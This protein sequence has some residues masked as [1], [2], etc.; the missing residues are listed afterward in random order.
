MGLFG[1]HRKSRSSENIEKDDKSKIKLGAGI[2]LDASVR[3]STAKAN[4]KYSR[5]DYN[6]QARKTYYDDGN[7]HKSAIDR[8]FSSGKTVRDP[9]SGAKLVK[10]QKQ[11]KMQFGEDWQN[12]AAEADHIDPLSQIANRTKKNPFLTT[13]DVREIGNSEDNFQ[14]LSRKLNQTNKDVGKGGSTQ[15]EWA[16]DSTRMEGLADNIESGESIETVKKRIKENGKAAEKRN[17]KRAY[18]KGFKNAIGTAR[19][20]GRAG[21]QNAGITALT[22]SGIMNVVSVIK[23]EKRGEEAVTDTIRDGGKAA[24]TGYAM[25]G[26]LTVVSQ[27]LSYSSSEFVQALAKSNVPGKVITAVLVTGD[28][29]KKWGNGE[30][31]TQEC[32]IQLGDKGL[33]MATMGY[34]MAV[35]Q[36]LIP[37]PVVGGA[38]GALVGA[39]LTTNLY[40]GLMNDLQT[41]QLEHQERMRIIAECN[42][43]AEQAR[44]FREQLEAYLDSYFQEYKSCF[45]EAMS[46]IHLAYQTNDADGIIAGANQITRKMGGKVQ[47]ETVEEFECFLDD[48]SIDVL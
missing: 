37:I 2:A 13:D 4:A 40:N 39:M 41:K 48:D 45:D 44:M 15:A 26:G 28:T 9:Y 20:A 38:V 35:G 32:L 18:K 46:S 24:V 42:E 12:H 27:T 19:E 43:A 30:M 3:S 21:A 7:A 11:A 36:A 33:N 22:M 1:F 8:A 6:P 5:P 34:S 17:D 47:Y 29:L 25:G 10:T 31:T 23:G 16:D 14:V